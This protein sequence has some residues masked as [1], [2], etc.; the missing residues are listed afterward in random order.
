MPR[1]LIKAYED[2]YLGF[3]YQN[4]LSP[5]KHVIKITKEAYRLKKLDLPTLKEITEWKDLILVYKMKEIE[6]SDRNNPLE[7]ADLCI[8]KKSVN[9]Q[10]MSFPMGIDWLWGLQN[11]SDFEW[12]TLHTHY[13]RYKVLRNRVKSEITVAKREYYSNKLHQPEHSRLKFTVYAVSGIKFTVSLSLHS[14]GHPLNR[15]N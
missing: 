15:L 6:I 14:L 10:Q 12:T 9:E 8:R 2:N 4:G 1:W 11:I 5:E 7:Y 13:A 3:I